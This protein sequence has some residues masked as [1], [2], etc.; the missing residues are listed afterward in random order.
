MK[1]LVLGAT[2]CMGAYL[3]PKLAQRGVEVDAVSIEEKEDEGLVR[4]YKKDAMDDGVLR[5]LLSQKYDAIVD[6]MWYGSAQFKARMELFLANTKHYFALSSY[7]VYADSDTPLN[8]NSSRLLEIVEDEYFQ[9]SDDYAQ[10]KCRI[11]DTLRLSGKSNWTV[12]RP[13]VVYGGARLPLVATATQEIERK[14]AAG[15]KVFLPL[16]AKEKTAAI[17]WAG[18]AAEM[19]AR[20]VVKGEAKGET[21]LLGNGEQTTWSEMARVYQELTGGTFEWMDDKQYYSY[22]WGEGALEREPE[23]VWIFCYDRFYNR[24]IDPTKVLQATGL[25]PA[26]LKNPKETLKYEWN[27]RR[28]K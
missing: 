15:E 14:T 26:D 6:F 7:R 17:I 4:Y 22:L 5:E 18:D 10:A 13:V 28:E 23:L 16:S 24:K 20:L 2:G 8:E 25:T 19:I 11:E 21:Y 12:L 3:C 1:V 9:T 27:K